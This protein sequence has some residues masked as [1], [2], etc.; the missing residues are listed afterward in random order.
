MLSLPRYSVVNERGAHKKSG[1]VQFRLSESGKFIIEDAQRAHLV[2]GHYPLVRSLIGMNCMENLE[3]IHKTGSLENV[4]NHIQENYY[5]EKNEAK[6]K[7]AWEKNSK[8]WLLVL[9]LKLPSFKLQACEN[10]FKYTKK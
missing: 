3:Y 10:R 7:H 5:C 2:L 4:E 9:R 8:C 1:F 6:L